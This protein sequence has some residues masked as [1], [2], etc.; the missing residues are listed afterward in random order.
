MIDPK[1]VA[2]VHDAMEPEYEAIED[3]WYPHL[4]NE[5]HRFIISRLPPGLGR[6]ALDVG[7]GTG[8]QTL[9]LSRAGYRARGF[10]VSARLVER[11]RRK[12]A[13]STESEPPW[14]FYRTSLLPF[15]DQQ[16][17]IVAH[18]DALREGAPFLRPEFTVADATDPAAYEPGDFDVVVCCG[19]VLSFIDDHER[20]LGLLA[21]A[22]R[23]GGLLFLEV[24]Q[25]TNPDVLWSVFDRLVGGRL[26]Y[27]QS[28]REMLRSLTAPAGTNIRIDYPFPVGC[29]REMTLPIWLFSV[30]YLRRAFVACELQVV[31]KRGIHGLT[32]LFPSTLLH[33]PGPPRWRRAAFRVL[34]GA[35]RSFGGAWPVWRFGC[36]VLY[37]LKRRGTTA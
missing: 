5:I 28:W 23:V 9:L 19:S 24:E 13:A 14:P 16:I 33:R 29:G 27:E 20:V 30:G 7:C 6:T 2:A 22:V 32:N 36:S 1:A 10:D 21:S 8:F 34:A 35:E 25:R 18:T 3:L 11:A 26:G 31:S 17:S 4:F 15:M 37:A 12:V